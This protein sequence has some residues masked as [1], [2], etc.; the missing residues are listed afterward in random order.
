MYTAICRI[1]I[2]IPGVRSLKDKRQVVRS[3]I[4]K[5][6]NRNISIIETGDNDLLQKARIGF[7]IVSNSRAHAEEASSKALDFIED[8]YDVQLLDAEIEII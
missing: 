6:K 2:Y 7:A 5:L 3:I 1:E 4:G 8:N